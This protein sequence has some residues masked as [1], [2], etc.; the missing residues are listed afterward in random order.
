MKRNTKTKIF[1]KKSIK[2]R[3][4]NKCEETIQTKQIIL[5][6]LRISKEKY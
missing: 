1:K 6:G 5:Y 2:W 4:A 3:N